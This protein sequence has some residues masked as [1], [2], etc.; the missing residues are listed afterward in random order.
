[1]YLASVH[2]VIAKRWISE[3][4][5]SRYMYLFLVSSVIT[6]TKGSLCDDYQCHRQAPTLG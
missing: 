5:G 1:M 3:I 4:Q 6:C 2:V